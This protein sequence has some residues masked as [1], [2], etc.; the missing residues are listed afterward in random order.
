MTGI[1]PYVSG[2]YDNRQKMREKLPDAELIPKYFSR[3][4]YWSAGSG[5]ILHYFI[6]AESWD[7]YFPAKETENPFPRTLYPEKRPVSLPVGGPWQ[8]IETDWAALDATDEEFGGDYLVSKWIGQQLETAA[9]QAVL[10]GLRNLSATRALVC[11]ERIL[12]Q[13][14]NREHP[15]AHGLSIR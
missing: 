15:V 3:H 10:F 9:R 11:S 4:G 1:A 13:V 14:P 8:Y 2:L 12:R 7:E 6:D 5:K